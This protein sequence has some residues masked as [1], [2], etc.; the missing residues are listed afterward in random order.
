[1]VMLQSLHLQILQIRKTETVWDIDTVQDCDSLN[2]F[3]S[4]AIQTLELL[5]CILHVLAILPMNMF[6]TPHSH[7]FHQWMFYEPKNSMQ[8]KKNNHL[9]TRWTSWNNQKIERK[10]K[11][12]TNS[13]PDRPSAYLHRRS[14][15]RSLPQKTDGSPKKR[16]R[17]GS[18]E[19]SFYPKIVFNL[20]WYLYFCFI[21]QYNWAKRDFL[22]T[23]F[24]VMFFPSMVATKKLFALYDGV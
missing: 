14:D 10:N 4:E 5:G 7:T 9:T 20:Q 12:M 13:W 2:I 23:V 19:G 17:F 16:S 18:Q 3:D 15:Q 21:E 11:K 22:L 24:F 1:M 6:C 8:N